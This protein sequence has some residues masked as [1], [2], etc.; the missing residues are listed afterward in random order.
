MPR[1]TVIMPVRNEADF[2]THSLRAVLDQDYPGD[3]VEVLVVDGMSDDGTR[4]VVEQIAAADPAA[5]GRVEVIDNPRRI[6]PVA[7]N[8]GI[9]AS[10]GDLIVRVD[11]HCVIAKDYISK[12]V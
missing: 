3:A 7:M 5:A 4:E 10:S 12:V 11:G 1:V 9:A 6:A 2:I 8:L